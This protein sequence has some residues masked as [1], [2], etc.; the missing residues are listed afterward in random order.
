MNN[1][2]RVVPWTVGSHKEKGLGLLTLSPSGP[3]LV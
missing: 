3:F 2:Q 1:N